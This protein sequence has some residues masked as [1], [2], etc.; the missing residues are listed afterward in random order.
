MI[1]ENTSADPS[2]TRATL[3]VVEHWLEELK[4]KVRAK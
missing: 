4:A 2:S 3:I 1:K